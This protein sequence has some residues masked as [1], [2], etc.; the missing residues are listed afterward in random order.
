MMSNAGRNAEIIRKRKAGEFPHNIAQEMGLTKNTVIGVCWRAGI[1]KDDRLEAFR[2][3]WKVSPHR[4]GRPKGAKAY[5]VGEGLKKHIRNIYRRHS[6]DFSAAEI[7]RNYG[8]HATTV[9]AILK[10]GK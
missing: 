7:A 3:A 10:V 2:E 1:I 5:K 4:K 8:L 6:R 9:Y